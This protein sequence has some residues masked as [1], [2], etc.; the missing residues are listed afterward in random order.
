[1]KANKR[2]LPV[3][4]KRADNRSSWLTGYRLC[5]YASGSLIMDVLNCLTLIIV[6]RLH[7]GQNSGKFLSTVSRRILVRVLFLQIGQ[8][9]HFSFCKASPHSLKN[10][11]I[12]YTI[13]NILALG[14]V[15]QIGQCTY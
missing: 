6:S 3:N 13:T 15:L 12:D 9:T 4:Y 1:M 10:P 8:C 14:F 2:Y 5:V 7:L 11:I